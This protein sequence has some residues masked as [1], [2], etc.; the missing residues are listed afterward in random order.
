MRY[1]CA[2]FLAAAL[3][4]TA[5]G[6][7]RY[8]ATVTAKASRLVAEAKTANAEKHAPYEYWSAVRYL[9]MAREKVGYADFEAALK[10]G[11]RSVAMAEKARAITAERRSEGPNA[12]QPSPPVKVVPAGGHGK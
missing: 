12:K 8:I 11:D 5:C 6:P 2:C 1:R 7:V 4:C 10:Y 9:E 3:L